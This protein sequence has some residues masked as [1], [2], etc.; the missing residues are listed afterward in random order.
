MLTYGIMQHSH[1]AV[2]TGRV[3]NPYELA[4]CPSNSLL[5]KLLARL[6]TS[7]ILLFGSDTAIE[8]IDSSSE[9]GKG[10]SYYPL[11][12]N[13]QLAQPTSGESFPSLF[14][15]IGAVIDARDEDPEYVDAASEL[16]WMLGMDDAIRY[17]D[18]ELSRYRIW[19]FSAGEKMNEAL[20]HALSRFS[21]PKL[22][23]LLYRIAKNTAALS[24]RQDFTRRHALNTIPGSLIR[25]CDRA[26]ADNW[27]IKPYC[28]KWDEEEAPLI[29]RLFDRVLGTGIEGFRSTTGT[30]FDHEA[31]SARY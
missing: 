1:S 8:A 14:R 17:L 20:F 19:D 15:K 10:I 21:I 5:S 26:L 28:M 2:S 9:E 11:K 24:T 3:G 4:L 30:T 31:A 7:G 23:Y 6:R 13:W 18:R 29:T 16:W 12:V 22:R 25:D 27:S